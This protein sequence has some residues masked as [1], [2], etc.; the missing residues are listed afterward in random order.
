MFCKSCLQKVYFEKYTLNSFVLNSI[1]EI[2]I[3]NKINPYI[4]KETKSKVLDRMIKK[5][6][7][8]RSR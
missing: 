7:D 1:F 8:F 5:D 4:E 3:K 6:Y 2:E